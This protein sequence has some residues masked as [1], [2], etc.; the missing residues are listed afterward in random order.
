VRPAAAAR[1]A[2]PA[3]EE[4]SIL[5]SGLGLTE[6]LSLGGRTLLVL[7]GA[8]ILR[9]LTDS[10]TLPAWLGVAL[11]FAYAGTWVLMADLAGRAGRPWSAGFHGLAAIAVGLPLLFEAASRFKLLSPLLAAALLLGLTGVA[12]AV[13]VRRR[14]HGLAWLVSVGGTFT[15]VALMLVSGRLGPA[16]A[17]LVLLGVAALWLGYVVDWVYLRWPVALAADLVM[18]FLALRA[19]APATAE[20]PTVAL[21]VQALLV[22]GYFG[23]FAARTLL[24]Q[25]KVVFFEIFQTAAAILVGLGGAVLV[26]A[27]SGMGRPALGAVSMLFGAGAYAVAFAFVQRRQRIR[28][29]FYFYA[30]VAIVFT[31]AGTTLVLSSA[32]LPLLWAALA[33]GAGLL[34]RRQQSATLALHAAVYGVAAALGGDL[35]HHAGETLAGAPEVA[36]SP[37]GVASVLVLAAMAA[38]TWL[39]AHPEG[40]IRPLARVPRFLLFLAL[41]LSATGVLAGWLA[42]LFAGTP[43]AGASP[44]A[45]AT[46]RTAILSCG[47]VLL[48][49]LGRSPRWQ[50]AGWLAYPALVLTGAKILFEDL[51]SGRPAT[52]VLTFAFYGAALILVPRLRSRKREAPAAAPPAPP[53]RKAS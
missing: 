2:A 3:E 29:N 23:S 41:A 10:G 7:A 48:A 34:A 9:A 18:V 4:E 8:F 36:W 14:L 12:L 35:V 21:L 6:A 19:V 30:S 53:A 37:A 33:V 24:L 40:P 43:G 32:A 11:G 44:A 26:A 1:P 51:R 46:A 45:L 42:P 15:A 52:Q 28:E 5:P 16:S 17:Y 39:T 13:A 38:T 27:R 50:E 49:W 22:A 25:R 31:L 47:V 20:G